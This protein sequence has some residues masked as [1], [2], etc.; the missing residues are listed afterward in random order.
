VESA[1]TPAENGSGA[2][3]AL[4][5]ILFLLLLLGGAIMII[6]A[7]DIAGTS[8][9]SD[10]TRAD[11]LRDPNGDCFD[12]SSI[13]KV[14]SVVIGYAGGGVGVIAALMAL[15]YTITARRGRLVVIL[16]VLAILLSGLSILV[17][18]F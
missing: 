1:S 8:L 17:G 10:I 7:T 9:C 16:T 14:L 13:Q 12:G 11:V 2:L 3:R 18:N 5:V 6:A 15:A 4:A